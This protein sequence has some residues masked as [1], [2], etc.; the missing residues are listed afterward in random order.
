[1]AAFGPVSGCKNEG[2]KVKEAYE[3][4]FEYGESLK[5]KEPKF[6]NRKKLPADVWRYRENN[7]I[8]GRSRLEVEVF[9]DADA[10]PEAI[11][12]HLRKLTTL[13]KA[14][15]SYKA[16]RVRAWPRGLRHYGGIMGVSVLAA[17]G[18]G[19]AGE[20][21]GYRQLKVT[22]DQSGGS[23]PPTKHEYALLE[24]LEKTHAALIQEKKRYKRMAERRPERFR[25]LVV[26]KVAK[27]SG[28]TKASV[29]A[30]A[31]RAQSY[32]LQVPF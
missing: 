29:A 17:D 7:E 28:L 31:R 3:R 12:K 13:A 30:I 9:M 8:H 1:M 32:Y 6:F 19:W 11:R 22:V 10:E 5:Q 24:K 16:I 26:K 21:V 20:R 4:A 18:G 15:T 27:E 14:G 25:K 2:K 23:R